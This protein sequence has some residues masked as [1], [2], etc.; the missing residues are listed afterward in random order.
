VLCTLLNAN[1]TRLAACVGRLLVRSAGGYLCDM[2]ATGAITLAAA[3]VTVKL[4]LSRV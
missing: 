1:V 3:A 2:D 4:A